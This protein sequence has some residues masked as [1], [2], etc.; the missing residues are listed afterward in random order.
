MLVLYISLI[1]GVQK[2]C[3]VCYSYMCVAPIRM[4]HPGT[5][6][7]KFPVIVIEH[8]Q[9]Y[10]GKCMSC[11]RHHVII[12][13]EVYNNLPYTKIVLKIGAVLAGLVSEGSH[14]YYF[15]YIKNYVLKCTIIKSVLHLL[16]TMYTNVTH[17]VLAKA[18]KQRLFPYSYIK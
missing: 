4:V 3:T 10:N 11:S 18:A 6:L 13:Y 14:W 7:L 8:K 15:T 9:Y 2:M 12:V 1:N 16:H 5:P 17:E